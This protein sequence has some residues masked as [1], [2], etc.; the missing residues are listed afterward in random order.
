MYKVSIDLS[1]DDSPREV[2]GPSPAEHNIVKFIDLLLMIGILKQNESR[3]TMMN[4]QEAKCSAIVFFFVLYW[5]PS[6]LSQ[7]FLL[8]D[9]FQEA[10]TIRLLIN[11]RANVYC[12]RMA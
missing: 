7:Q 9:K 5:Q 1:T 6:I 3:F 10:L 4:D 12:V 11:R 8:V 2:I